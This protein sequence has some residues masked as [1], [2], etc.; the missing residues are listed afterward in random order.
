[1]H[2]IYLLILQIKQ[3]I[4]LIL[5]QIVLAYQPKEESRQSQAGVVQ[6]YSRK[7]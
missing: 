5:V 6:T 1:M 2:I 7:E 3:R 4:K